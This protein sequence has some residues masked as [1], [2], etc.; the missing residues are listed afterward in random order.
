MEEGRGKKDGKGEKE[1]EREKK[2]IEREGGEK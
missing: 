2:R 1:G